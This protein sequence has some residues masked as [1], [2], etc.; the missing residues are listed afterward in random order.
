[1]GFITYYGD[2]GGS[3]LINVGQ[4]MQKVAQIETQARAR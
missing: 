4:R 1:M 2:L 3:W